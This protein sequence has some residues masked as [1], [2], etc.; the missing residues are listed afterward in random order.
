MLN[1]EEATSSFQ[2]MVKNHISLK[3]VCFVI[4]NIVSCSNSVRGRVLLFISQR[5][6]LMFILQHFN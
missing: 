1:M 5:R 4:S 6:H 2:G 3:I